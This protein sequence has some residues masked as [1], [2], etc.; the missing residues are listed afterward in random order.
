MKMLRYREP[1]WSEHIA[2]VRA[3]IW[4]QVPQ[5][6]IN[7]VIETFLGCFEST[8]IIINSIGYWE[9]PNSACI[10]VCDLKTM[11]VVHILCR[12]A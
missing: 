4:N 3:E 8:Y 6:A 9:T 2:S 10:M 1:K 5:N 7:I 11:E 12:K